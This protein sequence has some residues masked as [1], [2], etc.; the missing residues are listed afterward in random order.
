MRPQADGRG[1][2]SGFV[3]RE[4]LGPAAAGRTLITWLAERHR[5]STEAVWRERLRAGEIEL[6]GRR[7]EA[8]EILRAGRSLA[9][10]RPAWREPEVPLAFAVL[11]RDQDLLAV[12]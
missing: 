4:R 6:D 9:W 3:Y 11:L 1:F 8:D 10:H 7:P 2:N 12:A 5:H